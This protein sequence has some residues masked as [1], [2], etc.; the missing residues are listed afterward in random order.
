M[1]RQVEPQRWEI[2]IDQC[3]S[4]SYVLGAILRHLAHS[5]LHGLTL[6]EILDMSRPNLSAVK[7]S[8]GDIW[9]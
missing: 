3:R 9:I 5:R 4:V 2:H 7:C 6:C 8:L 1:E